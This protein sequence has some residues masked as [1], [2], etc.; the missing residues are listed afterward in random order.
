VR[1]YLGIVFFLLA[2]SNGA[3][4]VIESG[5]AAA[6][7]APFLVAGSLALGL[8]L[9]LFATSS[10]WSQRAMG[11]KRWRLLHKATYVIAVALLGHLLLLPDD[12]GI[13]GWLIVAGLVLRIPPVRRWIESRKGRG[14]SGLLT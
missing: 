4:F 8:A 3:M 13:A 12:I 7:S 2:L 1:K 6:L 5:L 9:P 11:M 10:R 14:W